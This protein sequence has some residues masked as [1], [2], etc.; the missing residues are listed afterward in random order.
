[1][2]FVKVFLGPSCWGVTY[3]NYMLYILVWGSCM[4]CC[5]VRVPNLELPLQDQEK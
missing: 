4:T 3:T 5:N 2:H 1:M